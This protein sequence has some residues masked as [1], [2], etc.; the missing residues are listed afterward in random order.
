MRLASILLGIAVS[1][2]GAA[3]AEP[4]AKPAAVV[5]Q[6]ADLP[7]Q[8]TSGA[9]FTLPKAWTLDV[10]PAIV[11]ARPPEADLRVAVVDIGVAPD[12]GAATAKAWSLFEPSGHRTPK[13]TT[14][15]PPRNGWDERQVLDYETSPNE[16]TFVQAVALRAGARW[17][18]LIVI[19][20][21]ATLEKRGAAVGLMLQSLRPAGYVRETFAGRAAHP[22]NAER[23]AAIR[24][25]VQTSID[26]LGVPGASIAL[27]DHGQVVF[28][29]GLGVRALG[30]PEP[31]DAHTLFMIASNTKGM[32]T[33]LLAEL[34]DEGKIGWDQPVTEVYPSFRLGSPETT[35]KVL[36]RHL[37]CAC[38]GLPRKDYDWIF[39][40]RR[41][42]PAT[43][44][45]AQL[46]ATEPT[47]GFGEVF[48]YN[49]LMATA[50]GYIGAHLLYPDR[51]LGDAYDTAMQARIFEPL[52]M[53]E[54]TFDMARALGA[55]HASPHGDDL[56]GHPAL[57]NMDFNY[58]V[59]PY[60]PA[61]GAW[62]SSHDL[63]KYVQ[64]E[65]T[66]GKL[67]N[68]TRLVSAKNLL[69]RRKANVPTGEDGYY[70]MG[71]E[72]DTAYGVLVVHHGGSMAGFK[73]DIMLVPG[74]QVGAVILTNADDGQMLLRPFMRRLLE[75][76]YDGK[77]EAA[78]DVAAAAARNQAQIAKA[79][80][81]L[82]VP[83]G[84]AATALANAYANP[85]LGRLAVI[86]EPDGG[87][88]FDFG[89][90]R[91]HV[92]SRKNDD[93]TTSFITIDPATD[94]FEF[95]VGADKGKR[96]LVIRDGQ[97][98]YAYVAAD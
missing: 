69:M 77:P 54:T 23:V 8:T 74:A 47:S 41:D 72:G 94:G 33:L 97:H 67:P 28:E 83:A 88:V 38:T 96:T 90:W 14:A 43:T 46:A 42:T 20:A 71:L 75:V 78:G 60:R 30:K 93:A 37:V 35:K 12:A 92:A 3:G 25:F 81:R 68:G 55:D 9:R 26:Q 4:V 53:H 56:N 24:A 31:V 44:T 64:N 89:L 95:V 18:V 49:N 17:T 86:R 7:Y 80:E 45:F 11:V 76:L 87:V 32:S 79:R 84:P 70:G 39:N 1:L 59:E 62:S 5:A 82:V 19:G 50:A 98:A 21:E 2:A 10:A 66:E 29:G 52:G 61:G 85:D 13:L 58:A 27:I 6:A 65:I 51:D 16:K 34:A 36:I 15:R 91:S 22:L 73:S 48:Q 63:I 57:A 40:T